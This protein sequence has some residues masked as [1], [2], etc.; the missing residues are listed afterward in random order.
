MLLNVSGRRR[1]HRGRPYE[2]RREGVVREPRA[3]RQ[4][5]GLSGRSPS[6]KAGD[7]VGEFSREG[8]D[9]VVPPA[10]EV[11]QGLGSTNAVAPRGAAVNAAAVAN[12][13]HLGY[14]EEVHK[15]VRNV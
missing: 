10:E 9:L 1:C 13:I 5:L 7:H 14:R 11:V 8:R 12:I 6:T 2:L 3:V 4:A 15:G